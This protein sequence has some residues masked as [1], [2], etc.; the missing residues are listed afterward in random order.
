[1]ARFVGLRRPIGVV[2]VFAAV[3]VVLSART[4]VFRASGAL[5]A[6]VGVTMLSSA[7][8]GGGSTIL[9][10]AIVGLLAW[11]SFAAPRL[12]QVVVSYHLIVLAALAVALITIWLGR[13]Q[14][15]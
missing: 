4:D 9:G 14:G 5:I 8:A 13:A 1:M 15:R 6:V 10:A 2:L 7:R 12:M 3:I 11:L